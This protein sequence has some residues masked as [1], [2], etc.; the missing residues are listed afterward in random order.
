MPTCE[1]RRAQL[2]SMNAHDLD[3][4]LSGLLINTGKVP[5]R[6]GSFLRQDSSEMIDRILQH[7]FPDSE[8]DTRSSPG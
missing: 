2:E 7:E 1:E 5:A 8:T 4:E 3:I 6:M